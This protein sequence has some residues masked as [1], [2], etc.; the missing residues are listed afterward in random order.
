MPDRSV[1]L[2]RMFSFPDLT[3]GKPDSIVRVMPRNT[4]WVVPLLAIALLRA[5]DTRNVSEPHLPQKMCAVLTAR[6][7]APGGVL[8]DSSERVL[9]T[10]RL[11]AAIDHCP[12][13]GAVELKADGGKNIFLAAPFQLK[14]GVTLLIDGNT[15]LF[16][17]RNPRDYDITP[18]SCGV[19]NEK[20]HGC[21]PLILADHVVGGAIMGDGA[22]D[23]RGGAK[24]LGQDVT[25]WDLAQTA[26]V[27]GKQ[28]SCPR[29]MV[30]R[31]SDNFT[32]YRVTIRNSPNFHV[33]AERT[34][35]FT[36][37]GVKIEAPKR[38]RNTDGIDPSSSTNVTIAH[39]YIATGD[40]NVAIKAGNSG[41]ASHITIVHNHFY[42]GHG[43]SIG[44]ETNGGVSA[45]RVSDLSI[46]GADNGIRIKS[47]RSR[48]GLV[49][50]V[51][52]ENVCMRDV[53]NP[54]LL[55]S[56]YSTLPGSK[57]P[58]YR[59]ILLKDVRSLTTGTFTLAGLDGEHK[60]GVTLDN[61]KVD[62]LR[63]SD[64]RAEFADVR[65]G[66]RRGNLVPHGK[67][68]SVTG[69]GSE[70]S[71]LNCQDQFVPFP[72]NSKAPAAAVKVPPENMTL[73]VATDGTGDYSSIQR[74]IDAAPAGGAVVSIAPG[75]YREV[76]TITTANVQLR[77]SNEDPSKTI[78]VFNKSAGTAGGTF[79]S[80]TVNVK[81]DN[82]SAANLTFA[83]DFNATHRQESQ[84]SQAVALFVTGDRATFRNVRLLGN[85][86]T[87]YS[88]SHDCS[89]G[90]G[91]PCTPARHYF[92]NCYIEGNVDFIFGDGKAVFDHCEIH[93]TPH[94]EGYITAQGKHYA[95]QD[96]GFV[97][98]DC[99]LTAEPG[100]TNIWL[101]RPWRAY[102]SVVLLNTEMGPHIQAAGWREWRPG[103]T[104]YIE[105]VFYA[106]YQ[107]SGPGAHRGERDSHT[108]HLNAEEAARF[109]PNRFLAGSDGWNPAGR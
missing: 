56:T 42:S 72:M 15:A 67:E 100:V 44:S 33:V 58:L 73:Y 101:G 43:M 1:P 20:G 99:R 105:T 2:N 53:V 85:Q 60:V 25:W 84:G 65:I 106:E 92:S 6:L 28:Q 80:A 23:G 95:T 69:E 30:I 32:L 81:A 66:P 18:G 19:V 22:I 50:D 41:P 103:E 77:G 68:V 59:D 17:S 4:L 98:R 62:G 91:E 24:L 82:F 102:A 109:E 57:L 35:G 74:A 64:I 75:T 40:D 94:S 37:W 90:A 93:N 76:L 47:D 29:I 108:K 78:I 11:Q 21:K 39:C 48:G 87:V 9:D 107:S 38:A 27:T 16:G 70:G 51:V 7:A 10:E 45:V 83:N 26:K 97:F 5:Q 71:P 31:Q 12:A 63:A 3:R 52:Y 14:S 89:P 13:G 86:D 34:N 104:H 96:S 8:P 49:R 61:V 79:N 46:E 36:A 88:G 55:T 54:I